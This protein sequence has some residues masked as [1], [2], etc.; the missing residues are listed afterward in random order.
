MP[1]IGDGSLPANN[2][3]EYYMK[4]IEAIIKPF[5][6]EDVKDTLA[7]LGIEGLDDCLDFFHI[8]LCQIV[9]GKGAVSNF[10][11]WSHQLISKRRAKI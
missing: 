3:T 5:K 10:R 8:I 9:C 4:K 1:E 2:L 7:D 6:L 11:H